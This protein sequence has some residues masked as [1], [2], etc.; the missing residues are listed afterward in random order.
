MKTRYLILLFVLFLPKYCFADMTD[1]AFF[2]TG[3][4]VLM[5]PFAVLSLIYIFI[6]GSERKKGVYF[7]IFGLILFFV[8]NQ[9]LGWKSF[10]GTEFC[11]L[12]LLSSSILIAWI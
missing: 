4:L 8:Y 5:S 10:D 7:L 12:L 3:L 9:L 11:L 6:K 1:D 2:D